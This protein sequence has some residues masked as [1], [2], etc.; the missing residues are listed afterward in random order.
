MYVHHQGFTSAFLYLKTLECTYTVRYAS[1][2]PNAAS[3]VRIWPYGV[4]NCWIAES[5]VIA[6]FG[7]GYPTRHL[8]IRK[9]W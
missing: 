2:M 7:M 4:E 9:G 1:G 8:M 5:F 3:I 6:G